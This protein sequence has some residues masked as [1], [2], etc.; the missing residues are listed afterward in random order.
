MI[1]IFSPHSKSRSRSRGSENC[2]I[3]LHA[4]SIDSDRVNEN[5]WGFHVMSLRDPLQVVSETGFS[6]SFQ[7]L[8]HV[9]S[10]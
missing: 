2:Q 9:T 3:W 6:I 10:T 7:G 1:V 4:R 8:G 5:E